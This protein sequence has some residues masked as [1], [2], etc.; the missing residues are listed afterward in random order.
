MNDEES[1]SLEMYLKTRRESD[2]SMDAKVE[3]HK[4]RIIEEDGLAQ[5]AQ[6]APALSSGPVT[7]SVEL[8]LAV[9]D[10]DNARLRKGWAE[11]QIQRWRLARSRLGITGDMTIWPEGSGRADPSMLAR[12]LSTVYGREVTI[13]EA[14]ALEDT[15]R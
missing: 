6:R 14:I 12:M 7:V 9:A 15:T 1:L 13:E 4:Q 3:E 5:P 10:K 11:A 8:Q 2:A